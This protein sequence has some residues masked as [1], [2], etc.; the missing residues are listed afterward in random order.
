M[1]VLL[2]TPNPQALSVNGKGSVGEAIVLAELT[3]LGYTV[4]KPFSDHAPVDL[5]VADA[6]MRLVRLQVKY[7]KVEKGRIVLP[8]HSVIN[9][10]KV[11]ADLGLIDGWAIYNPE[12]DTV[13]YLHKE[14]LRNGA[15]S[16]RVAAPKRRTRLA[17]PVEDLR[18]YGDPQRLFTEPIME[19]WVSG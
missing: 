14:D 16:V 3:R 12:F 13:L 17:L 19:R 9:G 5:V 6:Q 8:L 11:A 4:F 18:T 7:R 2:P 10:K 1:T 15:F